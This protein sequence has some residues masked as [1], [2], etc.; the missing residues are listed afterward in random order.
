MQEEQNDF[1]VLSTLKVS[2]QISTYDDILSPNIENIRLNKMLE[3]ELYYLFLESPYKK[4]YSSVKKID[5]KDIYDL[6]YY[7]K[8]LLL[9]S[10]KYNFIDIFI[11]IAEFFG[12]NYS[13]LYDMINLKDKEILL[14]EIEKTFNVHKKITSGKLF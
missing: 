11:C 4:E 7:F 1:E 8:D 14:N 13:V 2:E 10:K 5:K 9:Q 6:F 12:I 3:E